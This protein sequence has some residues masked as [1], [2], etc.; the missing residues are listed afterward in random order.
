MI[1]D[2]YAS[3]GLLIMQVEPARQFRRRAPVA[4]EL[5]WWNASGFMNW[6]EIESLASKDVS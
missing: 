1:D 2:E 5:L 3:K 6:D 4:G